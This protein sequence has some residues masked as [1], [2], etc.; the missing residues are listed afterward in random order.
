MYILRFTWILNPSILLSLWR[1]D[2]AEMSNYI[3]GVVKRN[4]LFFH[5]ISCKNMD[6]FLLHLIY[7]NEK[8]QWNWYRYR[9]IESS[10]EMSNW[11]RFHC[12]FLI[13]IVAHY[14]ISYICSELAKYSSVYILFMLWFYIYAKQYCSILLYF[15]SCLDTVFFCAV[16]TLKPARK[17]Q[18]HYVW[19]FP[20]LIYVSRIVWRRL[21][22][23]R[24]ISGEKNY[25]SERG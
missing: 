1:G 18:Y 13:E 12:S 8:W 2:Y 23:A 24:N 17:I 22:I 20:M 5:S 15:I 11:H 4:P 19:Y 25:C 7:P 3:L 16:R 21:C 6:F 9:F 10:M 14:K